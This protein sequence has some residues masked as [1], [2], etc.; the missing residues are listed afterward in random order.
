[1]MRPE[2]DSAGLSRLVLPDAASFEASWKEADDA[3]REAERRLYAAWHSYLCSRTP[4]PVS[5]QQLAT[6]TRA[7]A[8]LELRAAVAARRAAVASCMIR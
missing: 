1:M 6:T 7:H 5:L 8:A 2:S 3:A 4:V